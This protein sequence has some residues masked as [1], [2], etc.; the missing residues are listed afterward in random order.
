[1]TMSC[2]ETFDQLTKSFWMQGASAGER[3]LDD[4]STLYLRKMQHV[5]RLACLRA[6]SHGR[7][8]VQDAD[9]LWGDKIVSHCIENILSSLITEEKVTYSDEDQMNRALKVLQSIQR[10]F[11]KTG[12]PVGKSEIARNVRVASRNIDDAL[13]QLSVVGKVEIIDRSARKVYPSKIERSF[14]FIPLS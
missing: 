10:I 14:R 5:I 11:K 2:R 13:L 8:D 9:L 1:M 12:E 4:H 6:L 3:G 7:E